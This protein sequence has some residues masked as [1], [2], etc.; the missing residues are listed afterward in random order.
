ML[1]CSNSTQLDGTRNIR[2]P[3]IVLSNLNDPNQC[4]YLFIQL[5]SSRIGIVSLLKKENI[6]KC[7]LWILI[8]FEYVKI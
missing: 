6:T 5:Q 3:D 1:L 4:G 8:N 2:Y 7:S